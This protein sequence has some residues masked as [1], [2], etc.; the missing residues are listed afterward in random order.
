MH[1]HDLPTPL[2]CGLRVGGVRSGRGFVPGGCEGKAHRLGG[3]SASSK[4][5]DP[6]ESR[7]RRH[8][9]GRCRGRRR[10]AGTRDERSTNEGDNQPNRN[11]TAPPHPQ[12][13]PP[14]HRHQLMKSTTSTTGTTHSEY[15]Y[16]YYLFC[17]SRPEQLRQHILNETRQTHSTRKSQQRSLES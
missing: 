11:T 14:T 3:G 1:P 5:S 4:A 2:P 16:Q 17:H 12:T 8:R 13:I 7:R 6:L 10:K 9:R 15:N